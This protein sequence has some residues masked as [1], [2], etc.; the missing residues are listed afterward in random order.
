M[1]HI[2]SVISHKGKDI[3]YLNFAA[4]NG[5][6]SVAFASAILATAEFVENRGPG[7]LTLSNVK[8]LEETPEIVKAFKMISARNKPFRKKAAVV[9]LNSTK[10]IILN[11]INYFS[12][13]NL[14]SFD[15]L[16]EAKNWLVE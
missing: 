6:E 7:Q 2:C 16:E 10:K 9:G 8:D 15:S 1:N 3:T 12:K 5:T 4:L 13:S 14:K 11:A